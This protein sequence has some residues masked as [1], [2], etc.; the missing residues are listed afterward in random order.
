MQAALREFG[1]ALRKGGVG[2]FYFA[3]HGVQAK[4]RNFLI[5]V[6]ADIQREDEVAY[7]SVDA[8][9][10]LDKM[11]AA[12]NRLNIVILDACRDNP[13]ARS[14]R[15]ASRGL[16]QVDAPTGT[17]TPDL[18]ERGV[19][20]FRTR[21]D[22]N[23]PLTDCVSFVVMEERGIASALTADRHFVQAGFKALLA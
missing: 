20:L 19:A 16:A 12:N 15:S 4:G 21:A 1:D 2:L 6:D 7:N 17:L 10:V 23:W 14:F 3:G 5:P 11:E 22:K 18:L 13:F 8:N 9:Q